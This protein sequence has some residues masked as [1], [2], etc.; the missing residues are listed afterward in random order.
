M[1]F[2][3]RSIVTFDLVLS[4]KC[5]YITTIWFIKTHLFLSAIAVSSRAAFLG[6]SGQ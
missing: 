1:E 5:G 3:E 2:I 4:F 6:G